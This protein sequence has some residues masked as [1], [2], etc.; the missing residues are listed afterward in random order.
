METDILRYEEKQIFALRELYS[1]F[2]YT[3]YRMSKFEEYELYIRHKDFMVSDRVI[4]FNDT[5]G[6]LLALKPDVT[7]SIIKDG[8]DQKGIK[9]KVYYNENVY[10]VSE[11]THCFKEIQQA[12]LECI[13][14]VD[15]YDVYE[16]ISLGARSLSLVSTEYALA[17]SHL[18]LISEVLDRASENP[19]FQKGAL[20]YI[21]KKNSHDLK[22]LCG[23]WNVPEEGQKAL[24]ILIEAYGDR[25]K[26][27]ERLKQIPNLKSM[28]ELEKISALLDGIGESKKIQFDFSLVGDTNYYNGWTFKGFV[29]G[30]ASAVLSGGRYDRMMEKMGRKSGA[31]GFAIYLDMLPYEK[32]NDAKPDVDVLLVYKEETPLELLTDKVKELT[33]QGLR[34]SAQKDVPEKLKFGEL[35]DLRK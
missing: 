19:V 28:E 4:S 29:E 35:I 25:N 26:V 1:G 6:K 12:G 21:S 10:R 30:A 17:V 11:S 20:E 7:L 8:I 34:I 22:K 3:P 2:G 31:I 23:R 9:Q 13:G 14:D 15:I 18:G 24:N 16:V 32:R 5:D 27:L 33:G